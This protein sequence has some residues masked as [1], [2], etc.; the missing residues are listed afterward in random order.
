MKNDIVENETI[1]LKKSTSELND[2]MISISSILNK[3]KEGV[4][5]FGVKNDGSPI[6]NDISDSTLRDISRK[7]FESIKPQIIPTVEILLYKK[8]NIIKVSFKGNDIP[9]SAFG[10]YYIRT[11]DEDRELNPIELRKIMISK[12]YEES[13]ENILSDEKISDVS[14]KTVENFYKIATSCKRMPKTEYS[15]KDLLEKL[16]LCRNGKLTNAGKLLFSKNKPITLKLAVFAGNHKETFLDINTVEGNIF[17]LIDES[18]LYITKNI[19]WSKQL[20]SDNVHRQ[21]IPEM[22]IEAIRE[23]VIN[24]FCHARYDIKV[25]HEISIFSDRVVITNP[26]AFANDYEPIDFYKHDLKSYLRNEKISKVLYLCK[27]VETFGSGIKKIY[28]LCEKN[29][30]VIDYENNEN[31]FS[32][33]FYRDEF[34]Y[35]KNGIISGTINKT[36]ESILKLLKNNPNMIITE[37]SSK[38]SI[39]V[40]TINRIL[41]GLKKRGLI[42]RQGSKKSGFWKVI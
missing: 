10:K 1:E 26:G 39:P 5:Y 4:L 41:D 24:S 23:A 14:K 38:L 37:I 17:E 32:I 18:M 33:T 19:R 6:K 42:E 9:Y 7:I 11:A 25:N 36:E 30:I 31:D 3:H 35:A 15:D 20:S 12:E 16:N 22:P 27:D 28:S 40:R 34:Y 8:I 29:S 13:F 2:A 21:E